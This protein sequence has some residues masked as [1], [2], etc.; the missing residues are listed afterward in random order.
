MN[1][2]SISWITVDNY[3]LDILKLFGYFCSNSF[4][5]TNIKF[6]VS[7]CKYFFK[8]SVISSF[9]RKKI[10]FEGNLSCK[11]QNYYL[12]II[13]NHTIKIYMNLWHLIWLSQ[14][15]KLLFIKIELIKLDKTNWKLKMFMKFF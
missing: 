10:I 8:I 1:S 13:F 9:K 11:A 7:A 6:L 14:G 12:C 15:L 2:K 5:L 3:W 4:G